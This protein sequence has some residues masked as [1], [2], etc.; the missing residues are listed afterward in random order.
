M[1]GWLWRVLPGHWSIRL[2]IMLV[3]LSAV[4]VLLFGIVFPW[5]N[6]HLPFNAVTVDN[7]NR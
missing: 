7:P 5:V 6:P 2:L 3:L 1:Y 4:V